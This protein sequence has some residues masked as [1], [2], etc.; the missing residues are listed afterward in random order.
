MNAAMRIAENL[1]DVRSRIDAAAQ[2]SGRLS[3]DICLIAVTK[4]V[5]EAITRMIFEAGAR[6]LGE[7][8]PQQLWDKAEAFQGDDVQW[9][10]V[11][12]L[13]RNKIRRT[14]PWKPLIHSVDRLETLQAINRIAEELELETQVLL[15]VNTSGDAAKDGLLA[16]QLPEVLEAAANLQHVQIHGLMTMAALD[17][18]DDVARE[19]FRDL[20][21][22][23]DNLL[24]SCPDNVSLTELSMGM[25]DDFEIAIEE[26]ATMI[27]VGSILFEGVT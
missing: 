6:E 20:R 16:E 3:S 18:G 13:Q 4:Y 25:S 12:H 14:L 7:S 21:E 17:G 19:N 23:R 22:L 15:E 24:P 11:G 10:L 27:R 8:R 26:G 5:D 2:R 1:N 9:H